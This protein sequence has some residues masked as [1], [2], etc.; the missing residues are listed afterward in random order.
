MHVF[1]LLFLFFW[2]L[3]FQG[4]LWADP[5]WFK[6]EKKWGEAKVQGRRIVRYR[7]RGNNFPQGQRFLLT[8]KWFNG[9]E[10]EMFAYMANRRGYLILEEDRRDDPIYALCPL[11]KGERIAFLMRSEEDPSFLA[12]TS[13]VPFPLSLKTKSG[14]KLSLELQAQDGSSF[15]L[16]GRGFQPGET[17]GMDFSFQGKDYHYSLI[18]SSEGRVNFP[19]TF[20]L[21]DRDGG[22][23]SL[24]LK[25]VNEEIIF[26]FQA[27]RAAL[28]LIGGFALEIR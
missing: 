14:L 12:Q 1:P 21:D 11:K 13:V 15:C 17:C 18:A 6:C 7:L 3:L 27:G 23:C 22:E 20:E 10:A 26:P 16:F 19:F 2:A 4:H 24:I 25:R 9:E 28:G 5:P 8:I